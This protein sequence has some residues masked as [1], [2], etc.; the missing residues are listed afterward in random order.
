MAKK[1]NASSAI[2][3]HAGAYTG[4]PNLPDKNKAQIQI[5]QVTNRMANPQAKRNNRPKSLARRSSIRAVSRPEARYRPQA[6]AT[7]YTKISRMEL[8]CIW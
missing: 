3:S 1:Q 6:P 7:P 4:N 2:S 5:T 8:A